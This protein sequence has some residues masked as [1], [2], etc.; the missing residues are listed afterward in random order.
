MML[1]KKKGKLLWQVTVAVLLLGLVLVYYHFH[2]Y[3][4]PEAAIT[5]PVDPA[6][7]L[8]AANANRRDRRDNR[9]IGVVGLGDLAARE[10]EDA[11]EDGELHRS[12][13]TLGV[14]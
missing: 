6:C 14:R 11:L 13:P 9:H 4:E 12:G 7:D 10:D 3:F 8:R 1:D 2:D 5:V